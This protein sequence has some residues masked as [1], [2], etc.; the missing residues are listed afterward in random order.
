MQ[1]ECETIEMP[2]QGWKVSPTYPI[3][4]CRRAGN[5][6]RTFMLWGWHGET[7]QMNDRSIMFDMSKTV[8]VVV[9]VESK[10][11]VCWFMFSPERV[12]VAIAIQA[13]M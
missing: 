10:A 13:E 4:H 7:A 12:H 2:M 11:S 5:I 1:W 3:C 9:V 8:A 6:I